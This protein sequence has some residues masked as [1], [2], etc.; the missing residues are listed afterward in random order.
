MHC[1]PGTV[2]RFLPGIEWRL[3]PVPG[4]DAGGQLQVRG[5]TVMLGYLRD[6][7]PGVLESVPDG[8]YD[9]GD[10]VAVDA[11][12]FVSIVGRAKR[13]AKIGGEMVSMTAAEALVASLWPDARHA[14]VSV[15]D[16]RKGEALL[17]V[18]TQKNA[19]PRDLLAFARQR[20]VP[21]LMV[22]RSIQPVGSVPLLATGKVDYPA[23][24]RLVEAARADATPEV[25]SV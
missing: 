24:A 19:E 21:E 11:A 16:A 20:S 6:T 3:Q 7:A 8:W 23:V 12:G 13:F 14:V 1:R 18:T 10:I 4:V 15:P 5:P 2:G 9:T 22:P 17:L 25:V